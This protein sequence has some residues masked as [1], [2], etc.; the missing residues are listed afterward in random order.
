MKPAIVATARLAIRPDNCATGIR[1]IKKISGTAAFTA[2]SQYSTDITNATTAQ[3][4]VTSRDDGLMSLR[5]G[6]NIT[7]G[8]MEANKK[9]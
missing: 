2:K 5:I 3:R 4:T 6:L 7:R 1:T 8:P 9:S